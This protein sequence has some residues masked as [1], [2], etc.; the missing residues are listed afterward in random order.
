MHQGAVIN[1]LAEP[2]AGHAMLFTIL[3]YLYRKP[4]HI[5][6]ILRQYD[7]CVFIRLLQIRKSLPCPDICLLYTSILFPTGMNFWTPMICPTKLSAILRMSPMIP[8]F[9]MCIRD[10]DCKKRGHF[11]QHGCVRQNEMIDRIKV[12]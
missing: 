4:F 8:R 6:R 3:L 10:R 5:I 1:H 12:T 9:K 2:E 11:I 7:H